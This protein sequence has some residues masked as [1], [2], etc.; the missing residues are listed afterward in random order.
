MPQQVTTVEPIEVIRVSQKGDRKINQDRC[1]IFEHDNIKVLVLA[2][3]MGGHPKGEVAAQILVDTAYHLL[4]QATTDNFHAERYINDVLLSAHRNILKYGLKKKPAIYPRTTAVIVV[5]QNN[6]MQW[7]HLGDSRTYLFRHGRAHMRTLDHTR[8]EALRLSGELEDADSQSQLS[9]R[10]GVSRCLGG[11][12]KIRDIQVTPAFRLQNDDILLLC[13]DGIWSQLK[14]SELE[15][16]IL[17]EK[18]SLQ[19][20]VTNLVDA[21]VKAGHPGS[22]NATAM[23][24]CWHENEPDTVDPVHNKS[25]DEVDSAIDHLRDLIDR[26]Q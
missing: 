3:G 15:S 7:S 10:S 17:Q 19:S 25:I 1:E 21:A 14:Q 18:L 24:L 5:I 9:G 26:Y 23:A 20:R 12:K 6:L 8:A 22:D 2:D 16:F 11:M 4:N 13:S